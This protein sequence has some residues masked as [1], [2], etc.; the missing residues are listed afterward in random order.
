MKVDLE[1]KKKIIGSKEMNKIKLTLNFNFVSWSE[2][3]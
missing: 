1:L 2:E 3:D